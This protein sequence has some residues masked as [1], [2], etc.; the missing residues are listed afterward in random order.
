M[1]GPGNWT[2]VE[3]DCALRFY[4]TIVFCRNVRKNFNAR[5]K[6][7]ASERN[8]HFLWRINGA[9]GSLPQE[10]FHIPVAPQN[11][12]GLI[13]LEA[14]CGAGKGLQL[15]VVVYSQNVDAVPLPYL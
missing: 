3:R 5:K 13:L 9:G 14:V 11:E 2:Y 10:L 6:V 4:C 15:V 12:N 1:R 7:L 8:K